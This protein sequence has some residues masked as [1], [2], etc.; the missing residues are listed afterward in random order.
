MRKVAVFFGGASCEH[1]VSVITG[2]LA[3][4]LLRGA[5]EEVFPVYL[6]REGGMFTSPLMTDVA[7]FRSPSRFTPVVFGQGTICS[8]KG[9]KKPLF[10]PDVALNCCH[11]GAGE[12]GTLSALLDWYG[13]RSASPGTPVSA[14]F[15]NKKLSALAACG[16][17]LPVA[18]SFAVREEEWSAEKEAVL[19]RARELGYPVVVKPCRLGS[20]I[21]I[22][23]AQEEE[24]LER[25]LVKAFRYDGEALV[26]E[27]FADKR[28]IN[29]AAY[30]V[31]GEIRV[32]LCE[33]AFS[34]GEILS[35][36]EKYGGGERRN[37]KLPAD[38]PE[39]TAED[40]RAM[41]ARLY[42]AFDCR[43]IVRA[44]FILSGG[45]AY[46]N[47]LNTVPGSL[48]CYLFGER[49]SE[50][51]KLLLSLVKEGAEQKREKKATP[52]THLLDSDIFSGA[53]SCKERRNLV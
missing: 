33:E 43:G 23:V 21:G 45:K 36:G 30:R 41:T 27:Y 22:S 7:A 17:G 19:L 18:R 12:D 10:A 53:K 1:D 39:D 51:K 32:S 2:M 52:P 48:A 50:A 25:A 29:C 26:E 37:A 47:E 35:F 8:A 44:D 16:A 40:I 11:G 38:L 28:D 20:S 13:I 4:N 49:L 14:L 46:F 6:G 24:A 34:S 31:G 15:M 3:V 9:R 5:G 42:D